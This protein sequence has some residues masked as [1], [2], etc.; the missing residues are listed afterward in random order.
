MYCHGVKLS[1][2]VRNL[3]VGSANAGLIFLE[4][5]IGSR[6]GMLTIIKILDSD[7]MAGNSIDIWL[8]VVER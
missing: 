6:S 4:D 3:S 8:V 7:A 5:K 1:S 2:G